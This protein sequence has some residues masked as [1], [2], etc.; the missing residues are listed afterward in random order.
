MGRDGQAQDNTFISTYARDNP[1][2]E[3][4]AESFLPYLAVRYRPERI[5]QALADTIRHAIPNRIA[6]F[7]AQSFGVA[8][9]E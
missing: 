2:R 6:Y 1:T 5:T 3:D 9:V 7:D 8:P 4:L